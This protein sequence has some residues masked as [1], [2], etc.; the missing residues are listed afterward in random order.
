MACFDASAAGSEARKEA[1]LEFW[2]HLP[3]STL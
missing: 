3:N 2:P 1:R